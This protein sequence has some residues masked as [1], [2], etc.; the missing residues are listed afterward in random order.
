MVRGVFLALLL[1]CLAG[2]DELP[3]PDTEMAQR[4]FNE[5]AAAYDAH[6]YARAL[7][8]F[9]AA[10]R[11][12][13]L[14]AFD[15]NIARCHDR[16]GHPRE[17]I[18]SYQRY[19]ATQPPDTTEIRER[20]AVL[21]TRVQRPPPPKR[22]I[23][24]P[25]AVGVVSLALLATGAGLAGSIGP[26]YDALDRRWRIDGPTADIRQQADSLRARELAGWTLLGAGAAAAVVDVALIIVARRRAR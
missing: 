26:D 23:A 24:A 6:D 16:L 8:R 15:Y 3:D 22:S 11:L 9:E 18:D 7:E 2:A 25:V 17:A 1:P 20:I 14:P 5:G 4:L 10:R 12:K 21:E 19:L 13:P